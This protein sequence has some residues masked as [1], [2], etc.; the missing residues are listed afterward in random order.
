LNKKEISAF[1]RPQE[2]SIMGNKNS[3]FAA[4]LDFCGTI[5]D[6]PDFDPEADAK[7]LYKA[8]HSNFCQ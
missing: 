1:N 4:G 5:G 7:K 6:F 2:I 3:N 8:F